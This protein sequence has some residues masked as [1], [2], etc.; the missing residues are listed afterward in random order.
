MTLSELE[1]VREKLV[2]RRRVEAFRVGGEHN[3]AQIAK[4]NSV[5]TAIQAIDAVIAEGKEAEPSVYEIRGL[6]IL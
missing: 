1:A 3:D 2:E 6:R 4:L 5:H